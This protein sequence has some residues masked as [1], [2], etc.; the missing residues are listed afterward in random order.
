MNEYISNHQEEFDKKL[1]HYK[2]ELSNIR[3]GRANPGM[4]ENV[5]V[6]AYGVKTPVIQLGTINVPEARCM[7]VEPWDKN[8]LKEIEKALTY[9]DLGMSISVES[10]IVRVTVPQMTEENRKD[11]V[12]SMNDKLEAARVSIRA[13]REKIKEEIVNAE[14]NK[15]ITEDDKYAFV[16]ELD[17]KTAELTKELQSMTEAKEK[18]IMTV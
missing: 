16:K 12:K 5:L 15:E 1:E 4:I 9:A 13:I 7:T 2:G 11:M 18:E 6:D 3:A 17:E 8:L 14:K 10:T